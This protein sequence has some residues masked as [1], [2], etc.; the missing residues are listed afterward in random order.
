MIR[1]LKNKLG[2]LANTP[3][4]P[5]WLLGD[6]KKNITPM[7]NE[8]GEGR[9][10]LDIGCSDK[11]PKQC[12]LSSCTYVGLDYYETAQN[13]YG[14]KPDV[15]GDALCLPMKPSCFDVVLLLDVLEHIKDTD[16][17]LHQIRTV[18]KP[19]GLMIVSIPFMY[20]LHD[21]PRDFIRLT[22]Y[23]VEELASRNGFTVDTCNISGSPII[24][25]TILLN[26]ALTKLVI[27][28]IS[29]KSIASVFS[30]LLP[31]AITV[32]NLVAKTISLFEREDG[33][34]PHSYQFILRKM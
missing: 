17:L 3:V 19:N 25:S 33:F 2:F 10:V 6:R 12:L 4:H 34:M 22:V 15:Y 26:I 8:I 27:N 18:L 16:R 32:N 28:W 31:F 11:W 20:P 29:G 13:W 1:K 24:T 7:I 21:E 30:I 5:Q 9:I 14:T 23:G